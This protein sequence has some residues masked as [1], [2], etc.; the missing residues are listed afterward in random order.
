MIDYRV[1]AVADAAEIGRFISVDSPA[2]GDRFADAL[3]SS[4]RALAATPHIGRPRRF[5]RSDL[6]SVR[7][8]QVQGFPNHLI[9][10]RVSESGVLTVLRVIHAARELRSV[11]FDEEP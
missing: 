2:A 7:S 5:R 11:L 4:V 1:R 6:A 9:F 8:W 3:R 10:Y